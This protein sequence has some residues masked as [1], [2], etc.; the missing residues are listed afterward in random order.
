M[1]ILLVITVINGGASPAK[2]EETRYKYL[3]ECIH[4]RN[5]AERNQNAMGYCSLERTK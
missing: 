3:S 2:F 5:I 1:W 4:A